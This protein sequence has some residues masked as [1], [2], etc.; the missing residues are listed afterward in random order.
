MQN[1][2]HRGLGQRNL[3]GAL[4]LFDIRGWL[5]IVTS[6]CSADTSTLGSAAA[7]ASASPGGADTGAGWKV[8]GRSEQYGTIRAVNS[9]D[10]S[11]R[12][13]N[14]GQ[15]LVRTGILSQ[16]G[17]SQKGIETIRHGYKS[18]QRFPLPTSSHLWRGEV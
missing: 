11:L 8:G 10:C 4:Q 1:A 6:T 5:L 16:N 3:G 2:S 12:P 15:E 7:I 13:R 18:V 9:S 17:C 14:S